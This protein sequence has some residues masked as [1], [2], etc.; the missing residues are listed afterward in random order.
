MQ[1]NYALAKAYQIFHRW[2]PELYQTLDSPNPAGSRERSDYYRR[3]QQ[4]GGLKT[5]R[6]K[7]LKEFALKNTP[8]AQSGVRSAT[9]QFILQEAVGEPSLCGAHGSTPFEPVRMISLCGVLASVS[10]A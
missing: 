5:E 2:L 10:L 9:E 7:R 6:V 8:V 4:Y 3:R 1:G